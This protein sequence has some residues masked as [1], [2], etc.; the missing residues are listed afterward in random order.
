MGPLRAYDDARLIYLAHHKK[1]LYILLVSASSDSTHAYWQLPGGKRRIDDRG[2]VQETLVRILR[3]QFGIDIHE[4]KGKIFHT[5]Q[6][7]SD[8]HKILTSICITEDIFEELP[9]IIIPKGKTHFLHACWFQVGEIKDL[10]FH[11]KHINEKAL[12]LECA[13]IVI[14]DGLLT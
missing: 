11:R 13:T 3:A 14:Q 8:D 2:L 6:L 1:S 9:R 5:A 4:K 10:K 7:K 12:A